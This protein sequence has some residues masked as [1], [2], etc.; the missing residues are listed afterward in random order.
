MDVDAAA[1]ELYGLAPADFTRTRDLRAAE[2]RAAGD[3]DAAMEIARLR[4]PSMAAHL[5]N[6]LAR[7]R[8][9][10]LRGLVG[11]GEALR[12]AQR[13]LAGD[14]LRE[15]SQQRRQ[16]VAGLA[17]EAERLARHAGERVSSSAVAEAQQTLEAALADPAAAGA[18]VAG[19]L[20]APL[21][22][23]GLGPGATA[24]PMRRPASTRV[25]SGHPGRASTRGGDAGDAVE[26]RRHEALDRASAEA[27]E[28]AM[29][30]AARDR[31]AGEARARV[32]ELRAQVTEL[33]ERLADL[34]GDEAFATSRLL[35]AEKARQA[36]ARRTKDAEA[37]LGRLQAER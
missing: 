19:R 34:R 36:A 30:A 28:A 10:E 31:D 35:E 32:K 3:R 37:V 25:P 8:A 2:A 26:R 24:A 23:T 6:L 7:E 13:D 4:R 14:Q 16:V 12:G 27:A 29:A 20:S 11:L 18:V 9:D 33:E 5:V 1:D 15:L 22:Y 17:M 21:Q